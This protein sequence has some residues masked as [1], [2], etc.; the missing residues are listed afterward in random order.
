MRER[1]SASTWRGDTELSAA[2][3][4]AGGRPADGV[5]QPPFGFRSVALASQ[6]FISVLQSDS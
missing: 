2:D 4:A 6:G 3:D 1:V 5:Q